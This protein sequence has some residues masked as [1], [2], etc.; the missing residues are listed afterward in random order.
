M[1][2]KIVVDTTQSPKNQLL[3][4]RKQLKDKL[5]NKEYSNSEEL[6]HLIEALNEVNRS[7]L[8]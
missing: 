5:K 4:I 1:Y 8:L 6:N 3:S 7:P 2:K